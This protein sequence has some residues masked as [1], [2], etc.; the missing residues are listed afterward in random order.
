MENVKD[1]YS[2]DGRAKINDLVKTYGGSNQCVHPVLVA[3]FLNKY[4]SIDE[5]ML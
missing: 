3:L 2:L 4:D 5:R 1:L